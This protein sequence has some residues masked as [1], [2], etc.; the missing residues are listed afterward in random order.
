MPR[1][2]QG[3][4]EIFEPIEAREIMVDR[5]I[6][7]VTLREMTAGVLALQHQ[8]GNMI[9]WDEAGQIALDTITRQQRWAIFSKWL[10]KKQVTY[11]ESKHEWIV[12]N[13]GPTILN[14]PCETPPIDG[15]NGRAMPNVVSEQ[16]IA[17]I[18]L[19]LHD[20]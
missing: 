9:T 11:D 8:Q 20:A 15:P 4:Q 12:N 14:F 13:G 18:A 1:L 3:W 17:Q 5:Q 19:V 10:A 7:P 16:L 6:P 2:G